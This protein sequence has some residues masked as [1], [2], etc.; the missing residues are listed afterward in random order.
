M[1]KQLLRIK[2]QRQKGLKDKVQSLKNAKLELSEIINAIRLQ[3][4]DNIQEWKEFSEINREVSHSDLLLLQEKLSSCYDN[5]QRFKMEMFKKTNELSNYDE[6]I[7]LA[8]QAVQ[9]NL[10]EQEKLCYLINEVH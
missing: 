10:V 7:H 1:L 2:K 5:E 9:R 6:S 8:K 3:R 4:D